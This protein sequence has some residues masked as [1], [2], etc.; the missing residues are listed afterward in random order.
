[1]NARLVQ[2][3]GTGIVPLLPA[4]TVAEPDPEL[5]VVI[6]KV[7]WLYSLKSRTPVVSPDT[8]LP[9]ISPVYVVLGAAPVN[10]T[11]NLS[12]RSTPYTVGLA[13]KLLLIV[14]DRLTGGGGAGGVGPGGGGGGATATVLN[15]TVGLQLLNTPPDA[16]YL[17]RT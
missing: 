3:D 13:P 9:N 5:L 14:N 6:V 17:T 2:V 4:I 8:Y 12:L 7:A 11:V 15:D 10:V 1:M 16:L